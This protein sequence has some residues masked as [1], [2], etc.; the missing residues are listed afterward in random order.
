[1]CPLWLTNSWNYKCVHSRLPSPG[2]TYISTLDQ[3]LQELQICLSGSLSFGITNIS[4]MD[5]HLIGLQVCHLW[6]TIFWNYECIS[7]GSTSGITNISTLAQHLLGLQI[8]PN[9]SAI[10]GIINVSTR[11]LVSLYCKCIHSG[12]PSP[13]ITKMSTLIQFLL[14]L[15]ICLL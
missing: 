7:A 8:C 1:M 15:E 14:G 13:V 9:C 5:I 12:L 2:I 10:P 4:T 11:V 3:H 6:L